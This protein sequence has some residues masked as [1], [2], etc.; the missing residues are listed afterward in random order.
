M[1]SIPR[2]G[3]SA[4][5]K[6]TARRRFFILDNLPPTATS[7]AAMQSNNPTDAQLV[8]ETL[9]GNREAFGGLYDRYARLVRAVVCGVTLDWPMVHDLTQECFL[10][11]YRNLGRLREPER[12]GAWIVGIARQVARERKRSLRRDRHRFVGEPLEVACDVNDTDQ[13]DDAG[14][15]E[16]ILRKLSELDERER[17]AIHAYYLEGR[18][19]RQAAELLGL[20]RSGTYALLA[21]AVARLATL[22]C[23]RE[24]KDETK[25]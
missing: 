8:A 18:D 12:F 25:K 11:A 20:S 22:V 1:K 4:R 3:S 6:K 21:R 15:I 10:R 7:I 13:V 14:G 2:T 9:A 23:P 24:T 19:V 5:T 17:L 16:A